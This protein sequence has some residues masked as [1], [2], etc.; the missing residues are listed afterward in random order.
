[1]GCPCH[2]SGR[3]QEELALGLKTL[4]VFNNLD[5]QPLEPQGGKLELF[6]PL[7]PWLF[8]ISAIEKDS[9]EKPAYF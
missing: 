6:K 3:L 4:K 9:W 8:V 2:Q 1:M 5:L 7:C